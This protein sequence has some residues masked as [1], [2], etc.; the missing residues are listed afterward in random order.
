MPRPRHFGFTL[1]ELLVVIAIIGVLIA[2]L[3]PAVQQAREAARRM[4]CS[5]NMR[6]VGLACHNYH[7]TFRTLP[8]GRLLWNGVD[9]SGNSKKVVTGFLAMIMPFVEQGN[10]SDQ[11]KQHFGFDDI[12][13]R[14]AVKTQI[15]SYL[16]PSAP[17]SDRQ[18]PLYAGWN[19]SWTTDVSSL[20]P[21][22]VG[23]PTDYQG[24]RGIHMLDSSGAHTDVP[25]RDVGILRETGATKFA[26]ITDGTS[27]TLLLFE[28]AGKPTNWHNGQ[29]QETTNAQNYG[30]GPW[31]GNN[32]VMIYNWAADGSAKGCDD[33]RAYVNIDNTASPYSFHPGVMTIMLA[34][35]STR[36]LAETVEYATFV[37]LCNRADGN[38]LGDF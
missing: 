13:N 16:C 5:N 26:E 31:S 25:G 37:N 7:D 36:N 33:C 4:S 32:G 8:P 20:D 15:Q 3:L 14:Q 30:H 38:V 19:V 9:S 35:G 29:Q 24:V 21:D 10:L 11:Y 6:Q 17:G 2:L 12:V 1:V 23:A 27:N 18:T 34:D 22:V 28:M